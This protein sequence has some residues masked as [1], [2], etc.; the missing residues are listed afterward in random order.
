MVDLDINSIVLFSDAHM[1]VANKPGGLLSIP[2]G[3]HPELPNLKSML[4]DK[5]GRLWTVHRLDKETQG[6]IIFARSPQAHRSLNQQFQNHEVKKRYVAIVHGRTNWHF[7]K[8]ELPLLV[9]G[10]HQHRTI[11]HNSKGKSSKSIFSAEE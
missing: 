11:V 2:D 10:D 4:V 5:Y 6:I 9:N 7:I 3:Y 1:M 8:V